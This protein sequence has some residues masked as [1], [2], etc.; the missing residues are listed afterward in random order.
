MRKIL[1]PLLLLFAFNAAGQGGWVKEKNKYYVQLAYTTFQSDQYF[2][3]DGELLE[4]SSFSQQSVILY[5]EYGLG[6]NLAVVLNHVLYRWNGFETTER[7]S[8]TGDAFIGIQY[9]FAKGAFPVS[10]TVGPEIPLAQANRYASSNENNFDRI[11]LPTGDGEWNVKATLAGSHKFENLPVYTSIYTTFN[12]RTS[13][14]GAP[15]SNQIKAG[16]EIGYQ[17]VKPL[18]LQAKIHLFYSIGEPKSNS[19]FIRG[20]GTSFT[21]AEVAAAYSITGKWAL[22]ANVGFYNDW[23]VARKNLY[24]A[25]NYT[26]GIAFK[27]D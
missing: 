15:F 18:W 16:A 4:T 14:E 7:V 24:S 25:P 6:K 20:E 9:A 10:V 13:F 5:G 19:D 2:N 22:V 11:N 12:Y 23:L 26:L 8:G 17:P 3:L 21:S 1:L 27:P